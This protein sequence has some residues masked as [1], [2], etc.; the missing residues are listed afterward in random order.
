MVAISKGLHCS[1]VVLVVLDSA[2]RNLVAAACLG[3]RCVHLSECPCVYWCLYVCRGDQVCLS[4]VDE[5]AICPET[6]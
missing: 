2:D 4:S 1:A 3:V 6:K 5:P